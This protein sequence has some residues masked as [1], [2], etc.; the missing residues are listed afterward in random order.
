LQLG[1]GM[2][3]AIQK[4]RIAAVADMRMYSGLTKVFV[5]SPAT[6]NF[7]VCP[8]TSPIFNNA[9]TTKYASPSFM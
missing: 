8:P 2:D 9:S 7:H 1:N 6:V 4:S 5:H 3:Q